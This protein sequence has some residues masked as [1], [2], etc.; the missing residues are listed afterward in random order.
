MGFTHLA[1]TD[2]ALCLTPGLA[3]H[4]PCSPMPGEVPPM[5]RLA[6]AQKRRDPESKMQNKKGVAPTWALQF[7]SPSKFFFFQSFYFFIFVLG[8]FLLLLGLFSSCS[9]RELYSSCGAWASHRSGFSCCG[10]WALKHSGFSRCSSQALEHK[11][12]ICG[13]RV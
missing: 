6:W 8:W 11:L 3:S 9:K 1:Q 5:R 12:S 13:A 10:A 4:R 2:L 7:F